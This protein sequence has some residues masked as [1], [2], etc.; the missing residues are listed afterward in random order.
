MRARRSRKFARS[1]TDIR[2]GCDQ[3]SKVERWSPVIFRSRG[4]C[5]SNYSASS[6]HEARLRAEKGLTP[7]RF[8]QIN[9]V[10]QLEFL[11]L[12]GRC[13]RQWPE[14][15]GLRRLEP[16]QMFPANARSSASSPGFRLSARRRRRVP[17][18][19]FMRLG[20]HGDGKHGGVL[21]EHIFDLNARN[22]LATRDDDILGAILDLHIAVGATRPDRRC[23]TSRRRKPFA[24]QPDF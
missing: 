1:V 22:V 4:T 14:Q 5:R 11:D 18:P 19:I 20:H 17:R 13:L 23:E 16:R 10:A 12:A 3:I 9:L 2:M 7:N 15:D 8:R 21:V 24:W 6:V